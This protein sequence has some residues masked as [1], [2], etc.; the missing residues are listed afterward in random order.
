MR[1]ALAEMRRR[2]GRWA[3]IVGAVEDIRLIL[4]VVVVVRRQQHHLTGQRGVG[5]R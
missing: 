2:K 5:S 3:T 4:S 1:I